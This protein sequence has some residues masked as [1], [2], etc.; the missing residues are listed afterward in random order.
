[1]NWYENHPDAF[2]AFQRESCFTLDYSR[3]RMLHAIGQMSLDD[4]WWRPFEQANAAGNI[5][6]HVCGNLRQ[7]IIAGCG[8]VEDQRDR[9][10]EFAHRDPIPGDVLSQRLYETIELAK[11]TIMQLL[12]AQAL[13]PRFIQI[14]NV[15][16][17][18]AIT[19]SV[20]HLEGHA[21]EVIYIARL[22]LGE[23]YRFK[24]Q[25]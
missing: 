4:L 15:T 5:V 1:M 22:R 11:Q 23:N 8:D 24:D 9:P 19:H 21:Q 17:F 3:D 12:E 10:Q 7:W 16:A 20:V 18:G 2:A 6:L 13:Q 14:A 25:Y